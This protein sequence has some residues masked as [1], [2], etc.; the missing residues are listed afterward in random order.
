MIFLLIPVTLY[1]YI[2]QVRTGMY[3]GYCALS[4]T[5]RRSYG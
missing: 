2:L 3:V 1:R 4:A 5:V